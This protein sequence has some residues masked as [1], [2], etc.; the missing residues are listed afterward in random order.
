MRVAFVS[1]ETTRQND[2]AGARR[3]E[4]IART[5]ADRNHDVRL[6]CGQ[7]WNEYSDEFLDDGLRYR[8]VTLGTAPTSFLAR[9]PALLAAYRPDVIHVRPSPAKQVLAAVAG[10]ALA[11][12]PVVVEWYGDEDVPEDS[13]V[14]SQALERPDRIITPSELVRTQ[15]RERGAPDETTTVVPESIDFSRIEETDPDTDSDIVY[16]RHLDSDANLDDFLLGLAELR[17]RDW[18]AS[19][20]GDGPLRSEYEQEASKLRIDDRVEFL[21]SCD[22][23]TRIGIYR[24]AHV[25]VQTAYREYFPRELLWALAC[26]CVGIV[27]YQADSSAHELIENYE[28]SFRVTNPQQ[29]ADAISDASGYEQLASDEHWLTYDHGEVIERY[30]DIYR[31]LQQTVGVVS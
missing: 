20:I 30:L 9:L 2:T 11:R 24:G 26:G 14:L 22:R 17:T 15:V 16:A 31:E 28:R 6:F 10:G 19:I 7:F 18:R 8:G 1:M 13:R 25:F 29:L 3:F 4:R 23:E 12:A 27:E 5:L 21:G